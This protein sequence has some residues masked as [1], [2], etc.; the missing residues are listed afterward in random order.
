MS[1]DNQA[2]VLLI[3]RLAMATIFIVVGIR[4]SMGFAASVAYMTKNGVPIAEVLLP[5]WLAMEIGGGILLIIGW[6]VKWVA[7][8][9]AISM[10]VITPIFHGFWSFDAAQFGNQLNHFMKNLAMFGGLLY[11]W[12]LGAGAYSVDERGKSGSA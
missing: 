11:M 2:L 6:K 4:K 3:G 1:K 8:M 9:Y 10:I 12:V 7:L 5:I